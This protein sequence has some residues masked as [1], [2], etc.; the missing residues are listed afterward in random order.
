MD[1][2]N[3]EKDFIGGFTSNDGTI[4]FYNR[5]NALVNRDSIIVDLGA[6]RAAWF[7]SDHCE[8]RR[9]LHSLKN[10]SQHL[11]GVDIDEAVLQNRSTHENL[12]LINGNIPV[13]DASVDLVIA[14]YVLEHVDN[15][16]KFASEVRRV[17]RVG[18]VF[19]AR[20]PHLL[21]YISLAARAVPDSAHG[22]VLGRAQPNR[23]PEDVFT[24]RYKMNTIRKVRNVFLEFDD[25]SYIYRTDP[26]YYFGSKVIYKILNI[27]HH[28][29]PK[30]IS[31]NIFVFLVKR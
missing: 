22:I 1:K 28:V 4:E 17:L 14:D 6:G 15:P 5:V 29:L 7:E 3:P 12:L 23:K 24:T 31:G 9:Q 27:V 18:G 20:T 19:C 26:A 25:Y 16:A 10:K 11:I 21:N 13:D 8:Y 30:F 2:F